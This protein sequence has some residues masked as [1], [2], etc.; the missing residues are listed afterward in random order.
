[1]DAARQFVIRHRRSI[2]VA[3]MIFLVVTG[4][5]DSIYRGVMGGAMASRNE[6]YLDACFD[7]AVK[8]LIP[9]GVVKGTVDVLEGSRVAGVEFGDVMQ[10]MLDYINLAWRTV[11]GA[12]VALLAAKY[13]L[14]GAVDFAHLALVVASLS[15]G[16]FRALRHWRPDLQLVLHPLRQVAGMAFL[17][18]LMLYVVL[19]A[20]LIGSEALSQ[21]TTQPL[22]ATYTKTFRHLERIFELNDVIVAEG[23]TAKADRLTD[24]ATDLTRF[25]QN[26]GTQ[27]VLVA[28][29]YVVIVHL[30]DVLVFPLVM[31][32]F[33]IWLVRNALWPALGLGPL[34]KTT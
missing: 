26:E 16:L 28:V 9:I 22:E 14:Q 25:A 13:L 33:L 21:R 20:S 32:V 27:Q 31:L 3:V 15:Y 19:P 1:M 4:V 10:P 5:V 7:R 6:V 30:L 23:F 12:A 17:V 34:P 18:A 24:K 2:A 11:L 29:I 8:L